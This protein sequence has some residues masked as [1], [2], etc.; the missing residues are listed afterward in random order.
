MTRLRQ[1]LKGKLGKRKKAQRGKERK[2]NKEKYQ[3]KETGG[4]EKGID[5]DKGTFPACGVSR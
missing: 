2:G 1:L 5:E 4:M 3:A